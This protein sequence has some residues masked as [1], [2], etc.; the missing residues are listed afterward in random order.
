MQKLPSHLLAWLSSLV[1]EMGPCLGTHWRYWVL[2]REQ[3]S[4]LFKIQ[5]LPSYFPQQPHLRRRTRWVVKGL[6]D[7]WAKRC[8]KQPRKQ[9]CYLPWPNSSI[10]YLQVLMASV[11]F[12]RTCNVMSSSTCSLWMICTY[13]LGAK[14]VGVWWIWALI[15]CLTLYLVLRPGCDALS[16]LASIFSSLKWEHNILSYC[17]QV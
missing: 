16:L 10:H 4:K 8:R 15:V 12:N 17:C 1:C 5:L 13:P 7:Q 3:K 2:S 9:L 14:D 6:R 11:S